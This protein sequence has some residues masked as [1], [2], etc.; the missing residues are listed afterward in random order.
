M[1]A[2]DRAAF[3]D[4]VDYLLSKMG[5][6]RSRE[7]WEVIGWEFHVVLVAIKF[8]FNVRKH[9]VLNTITKFTSNLHLEP[10]TL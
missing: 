3:D 8:E 5:F 9:S 2:H 4:I 1:D 10:S 7:L 6:K